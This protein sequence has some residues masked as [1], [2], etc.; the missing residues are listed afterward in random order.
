MTAENMLLKYAGA[1]GTPRRGGS[2]PGLKRR[3][4]AK[5]CGPESAQAKTGCK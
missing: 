5:S 4:G 1:G 2:V 3:V